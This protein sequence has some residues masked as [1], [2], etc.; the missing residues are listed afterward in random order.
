MV[1]AVSAVSAVTLVLS[2]SSGR[3]GGGGLQ[4][5]R[6]HLAVSTSSQASTETQRETERVRGRK[7]E[8]G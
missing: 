2:C 8:P 6:S 4:P 7:T 5:V 3:Q 1:P